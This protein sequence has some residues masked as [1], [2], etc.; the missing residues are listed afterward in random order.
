MKNLGNGQIIIDDATETLI[1]K[2][3]TEVEELRSELKPFLDKESV[4]KS[5]SDT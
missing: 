3:N 2:S 5:V 1:F 4:I